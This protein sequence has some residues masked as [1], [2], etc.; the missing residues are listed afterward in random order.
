MALKLIKTPKRPKASATLKTWENYR[1][2]VKEIEKENNKRRAEVKK[3][4]DLIKKL[5]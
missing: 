1:D 2:R 5:K 4:A 3:K